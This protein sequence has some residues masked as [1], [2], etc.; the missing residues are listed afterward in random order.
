MKRSFLFGLGTWLI[1]DGLLVAVLGDA[2]LPQ[3]GSIA[4]GI[5]G[6]LAGGLSL[7]AARRAFP[8]HSRSTA[9]VA[10]LLAFFAA[11]AVLA[12]FVIAVIAVRL[13]H[14]G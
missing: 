3:W 1:L 12:P 11:G 10:W 8:G 14:A 2:E 4:V 9:V 6:V 13:L 5:V 7:T